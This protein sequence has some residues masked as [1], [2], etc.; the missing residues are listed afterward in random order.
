MIFQTTIELSRLRIGNGWG[1][2]GHGN[3][4]PDG[5]Y[6]FDSIFYAEFAGFS[7]ELCV[8]RKSINP[9]TKL[10]LQDPDSPLP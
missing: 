2:T 10:P 9:S 5:L 6:Q 1:D 4:V 7:K 3:A 8:H